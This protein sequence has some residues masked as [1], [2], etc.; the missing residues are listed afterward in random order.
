MAMYKPEDM[1]GT[2]VLAT[3]RLRNKYKFH[4]RNKSDW[5]WMWRLTQEV[6]ELFGS[7]LGLHKDPARWELM[8][9]AAISLNWMYKIDGI[10]PRSEDR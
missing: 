8:Q 10:E 4:W 5:Y 6:F 3:I 9:I 1:E 2:P 7:L